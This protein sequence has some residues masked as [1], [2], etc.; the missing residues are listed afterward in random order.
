MQKDLQLSIWQFILAYKQATGSRVNYI[1]LATQDAYRD[2][3]LEKALQTGDDQLRQLVETVRRHIE[4]AD[5]EEESFEDAEDSES[6]LLSEAPVDVWTGQAP[7]AG[8]SQAAPTETADNSD[9]GD[10]K[11]PPPVRYAY[12]LRGALKRREFSLLHRRAL[13]RFAHKNGM[14]P[15]ETLS[16]EN[17]TRS[18]LKMPALDWEKELGSV[19]F[20][21]KEH[22]NSLS[23]LRKQLRQTYVRSDRLNEVAFQRIYNGSQPQTAEA[24]TPAPALAADAHQPK[25][26][27]VIGAGLIIGLVGLSLA[28]A[29]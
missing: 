15:A 6:F 19:I 25:G 4:L 10:E 1:D 23:T 8:S 24:A 21:L 26:L 17:A 14:S 28:I 27:W 9:P 5:L 7:L 3:I 13:D 2:D 20:D 22:H 12:R 16:L 11:Q 18:K 29:I